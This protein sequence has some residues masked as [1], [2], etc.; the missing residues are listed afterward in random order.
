ML[1]KTAESMHYSTIMD[2]AMAEKNDVKRLALI[3]CFVLSQYADVIGRLRKPFN[4][5]LGETYELVTPNFRFISEQVSHHPPISA[6]YSEGKGYYSNA[7]TNVKNFFWGSSLEFK[8]IGLQHLILTDTNEHIII[9]R[10]DNSANNLIVGKLYV[11]VHGKLEVTNLTKNIKAELNIHRQGWTSKNA[12]KVEGKGID[13]NGDVKFEVSGRWNEYL[14]VKDLST[15]IDE[16]VWKVIPI[17]P[18]ANT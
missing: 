14:N 15:G 7:N 6:Y 4:P 3:G 5:I 16:N 1:Q 2:N 17:L 9:K 8:C 18:N 12:Y 13:A 11:D 10:P